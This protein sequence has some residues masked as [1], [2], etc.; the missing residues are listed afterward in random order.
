MPSPAIAT[1]TRPPATW[2]AA[3]GELVVVERRVLEVQLVQRRGPQVR[4]GP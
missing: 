2:R 3:V 4:R 1:P